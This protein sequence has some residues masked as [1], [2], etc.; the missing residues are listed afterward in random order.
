MA[1]QS[2]IMVP[3]EVKERFDR[4]KP[5][6]LTQGEYVDTLLDDTAP[7]VLT[8]QEFADRVADQVTARIVEELGR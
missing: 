8:S 1:K 6:D 4:S 2:S 5:G 7:T 3:P